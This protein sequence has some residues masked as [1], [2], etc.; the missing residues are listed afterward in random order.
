[1]STQGSEDINAE[2]GFRVYHAGVEESWAF[3]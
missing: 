3:L 1:M 2:L